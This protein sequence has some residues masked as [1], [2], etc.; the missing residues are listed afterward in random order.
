M[1]R[2]EYRWKTDRTW[3]WAVKQRCRL[4]LQPIVRSRPTDG[5]RPEQVSS[6]SEDYWYYELI[7][8]T[9]LSIK[10]A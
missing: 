10:I 5:C 1:F 3:S 9:F 7:I 4:G 2:D 6:M 8:E